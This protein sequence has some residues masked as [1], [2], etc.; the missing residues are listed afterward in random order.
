MVGGLVGGWVSWVKGGACG[1]S[2]GW[3]KCSR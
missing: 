1:G 2:G 3:E